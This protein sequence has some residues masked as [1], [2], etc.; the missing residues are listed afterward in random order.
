MADFERDKVLLHGM[1]FVVCCFLCC[2]I[3][4]APMFTVRGSEAAGS[5]IDKYWSQINQTIKQL[6]IATERE[7][8]IESKLENY[9]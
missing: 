6:E 4:F 1:L 7:G 3:L 9:K 5:Q 2:S 8:E